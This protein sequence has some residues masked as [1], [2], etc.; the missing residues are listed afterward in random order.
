P[1]PATVIP[2]GIITLVLLVSLVRMYLQKVY[3]DLLTSVYNRQALDERLHTLRGEFAL[4][5]VDIDHFKQFN[6]TYGHAEGDNVLRMV[7]QHLED[8]L[9]DRVYRYGGEEFCIVFEGEGN[10]TA[11]TKMEK[12]RASM[13][14]HRF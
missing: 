6:D 9:G 11:M 14:K 5:M 13:A 7:A 1:F 3:L 12:T 2:F 4:A 8:H 10:E